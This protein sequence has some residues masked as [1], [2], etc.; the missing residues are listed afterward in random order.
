M[1]GITDVSTGASQVKSA[2]GGKVFSA[3]KTKISFYLDLF[4]LSIERSRLSQEQANLE[5][6]QSQIKT[7]MERNQ[8]RLDEIRAELLIR[9]KRVEEEEV[10]KLASSPPEAKPPSRKWQTVAVE[11]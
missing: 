11:Y 10:E 5:K 2:R 6:R 4:T 8:K 9:A 7:K 3:P 1:K